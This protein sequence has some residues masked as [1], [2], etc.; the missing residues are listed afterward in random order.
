[1][2]AKIFDLFV[3]LFAGLAVII[4]SYILYM[5]GQDPWWNDEDFC[6]LLMMCAVA[7]DI[8]VLIRVFVIPFFS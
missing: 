7:M 8:T 6:D 1:M 4:Y 5:K 3:I 2:A